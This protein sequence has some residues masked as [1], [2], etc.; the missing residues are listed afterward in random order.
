M[1][2]RRS[3]D[4]PVRQLAKQAQNLLAELKCRTIDLPFTE[5]DQKTKGRLLLT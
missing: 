1:Y 3:A 4:I 2:T 5:N